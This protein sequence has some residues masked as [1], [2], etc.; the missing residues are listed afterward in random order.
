MASKSN[1]AD[2]QWE[3]VKGKPTPLDMLKDC[4]QHVGL[5]AALNLVLFWWQAVGY[6]DSKAAVPAM[7]VC[8]LAAGWSAGRCFSRGWN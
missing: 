1:P 7:W 3:P 2:A 4:A 8:A 5:Y 6:L